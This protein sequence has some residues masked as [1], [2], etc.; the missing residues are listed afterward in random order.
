M[1][2]SLDT[3]IIIHL[4][5]GDPT[6]SM[7]YE[8]CLHEGNQIIISPYVDFEVRRGL[9]YKNATAKERIYERFIF[10][11]LQGEMTRLMW[12]QAV[13]I[14]SNLR[15]K[16]FTVCDAD[17]LIAAFCMESQYTL[18]TNNTRDFINIDGLSLMGWLAS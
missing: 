1:I 16:G 9:R 5:V 8:K 11:W 3:N 14:Y 17:I 13:N 12:L 7:Q 6:I 10:S 15:H 4:L 2:L 18:V